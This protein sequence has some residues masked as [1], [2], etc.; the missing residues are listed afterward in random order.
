MNTQL[1]SVKVTQLQEST[2]NPRRIFDKKKMAELTTSIKESGIISPLLVRPNPTSGESYF[3]IIAGS[4]RF[5]AAKEV[6][7]TEIPV[8]I[9]PM[10]DDEALELQVIEND[11]RVDVHPLEQCSGYQQLMQ[12]CGCNIEELSNR[13]GKSIPYITKRLKFAD[14]IPPVKKMFLAE[15]IGIGH[16][17]LICRL[18]PVQQAEVAKW[19]KK[20]EGLSV[21]DLENGIEREFFLVLKDAPFDTTDEKLLPNGPAAAGSCTSCPKRSGFN[22]ILFDDIQRADVCTDKFCFE[23][24]VRAHIKVQVGTHKDAVLLSQIGYYN[25]EKAKHLTAWVKAGRET[26]PDTKE[27][28]IVEQVT[29]NVRSEQEG[30]LGAVLNVCLNPK[31]KAHHQPESTHTSS[32]YKRPKEQIVAEKKRKLELRRRG[33]VF[34]ELAGREFDIQSK[35]ARAVLD[36]MITGLSADDARALGQAMQWKP[37]EAHGFKDWRATV[38][39]NLEKLTAQEVDTWI[40]LIMLAGKELWFYSGGGGK[41]QLLEAKAR[42]VGVKL[43]AIAKLA[44]TKPA[45]VQVK[46]AKKAKAA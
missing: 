1:Q 41:P 19:L 22:T 28:V 17:N 20:E 15:E 14:L 35:D 38:A 25:Q 18:N 30:K 42:Q 39:K 40:Y 34:K 9:R 3:E 46:P 13:I 8:L 36:Y 21:E 12:E 16:A 4:R 32:G 2:F 29:G 45:K 11:Q 5:R 6:G 26:C 7:L 37:V 10:E 24:K 27:G 33:L 44:K 31:C 43:E 23:E